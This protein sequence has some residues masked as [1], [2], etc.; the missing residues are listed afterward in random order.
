MAQGKAAP[1]QSVTM[2]R[3]VTLTSIST[4]STQLGTVE[5]RSAARIRSGKRSKLTRT[6]AAE[7][8]TPPW[9]TPSVAGPTGRFPQ[10]HA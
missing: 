4:R 10:R 2:V 9:I 7:S 1:I 3:A 8:P 6:T 5:T